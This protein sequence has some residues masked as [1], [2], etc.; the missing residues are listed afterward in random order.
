[1]KIGDSCVVYAGKGRMRRGFV[2][3]ASREEV[4]V[5][6]VDS[7]KY[8]RVVR[9]LV[10]PLLKRHADVSAFAIRCCIAGGSN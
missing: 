3:E 6:L 8:I 1:M 2:E 4:R 7:G 10:G 5:F 9:A